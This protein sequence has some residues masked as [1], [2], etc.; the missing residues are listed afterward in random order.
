MPDQTQTHPDPAGTQK[1]RNGTRA[2]QEKSAATPSTQNIRRLYIHLEQ[3]RMVAIHVRNED[4]SGDY[5]SIPLEGNPKE[6][7]NYTLEAAISTAPNHCTCYIHTLH[8]TLRNAVRDRTYQPELL[9]RLK[10]RNIYLRAGSVT[11]LDGFWQDLLH[12]FTTDRILQVGQLSNYILHTYTVT[13]GLQTFSGGV[14]FGEGQIHSHTY[15]VKGSDFASAELEIAAWAVELLGMG[16]TIEL[17]HHHP[18]VGDFWHDPGGFTEKYPLAESAKVRIG[19]AFERKD[20]HFEVDQR[21]RENTI[22][23]AVRELVGRSLS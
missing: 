14:L 21:K 5:F 16:K 11:R 1:S 8:Q 12:D 23:R 15:R 19:K 9:G 3:G 18:E 17:H 13:D 4:S 20:L 7:L 10:T 6:Q 22:S 2:R